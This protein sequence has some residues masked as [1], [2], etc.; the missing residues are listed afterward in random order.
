MPLL[1]SFTIDH[2]RLPA[3]GVRKA[4]ELFTP[5]GDKIVVYD[6]RFCRPNREII[7]AEALHTLEHL[8]AGFM[9]EYLPNYTIIDISPMGCRTGF[10]MSVIGEPTPA[11]IITAWR[12]SMEAILNSS[13][14]P[15]ANIYQCGSC[16][17]HSLQK[18]K[19]VAKWVL[20]KGIKVIDSDSLRLQ[21]GKIREECPVSKEEVTQIG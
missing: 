3:P 12:K 15:E 9:R 18:A 20:T 5:K 14:I 13:S 8:F 2:T 21:L 17:L 16:Y 6:L 1:E 11:E 19:E 4:K 7:S 10:Y